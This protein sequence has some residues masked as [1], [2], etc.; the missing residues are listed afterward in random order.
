MTEEVKNYVEEM[1]RTFEEFKSTMETRLTEIE[2]KGHSDPL[3]ETKL[4]NIE[5]DLDKLEDFNQKLTLQEQEYKQINQKL[6]RFETMLK[7]PDAAVE[8]A[9]VDTAVKAF[10]HYLRKGENE[11]SPEEKK[12]LTVGDNTAA[13]FLAPPEY[14]NELIKTVTEIS[15][16][17]SIA[18]VRPTTQKSVQMPSRT[19][20]FS[21]VFVAEQGTRS[22]TT[23]YTTQQEEIPTHEMYALV[24]ISEA[25]L[26]DS[27]FNLEA[28]MQ[29]EFATQFAKAEGEKFITGTGVGAPEG[30]TI[31]GD[32]GTTNSGSGTVLTAN[33]LL[34]LVHAIKSDYTNNATF[35]FNRTTLAAI[36]KLQ[37]TA[38]QFVFQAGMMLTGGVPNTILG[39]PYVEMPDMP[40]VSSSAKPVAFGDFS[41]GYMIVDR[42]GLA[43]LRDPFTQ[44][45]S[46]NVRYYARKR[47]GGQVVLAEAIR[48]QTISA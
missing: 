35:V 11:L 29:Q 20:T 24:D 43:V 39:F 30:I 44:A 21:A 6:D 8:T 22:E 41:R 10:D 5:G 1:G 23:G 40:N 38:G 28:E 13:G 3:T 36:R 34:D 17:R 33:G 15:P 27:V 7:R 16:L 48:T 31:N 32:V 4:E 26:E 25:L 47:V 45:T 46:G 12:S 42:V 2:S 14:V 19:A 9:T 18:R 37:D